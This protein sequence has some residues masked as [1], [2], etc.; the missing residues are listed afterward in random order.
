MDEQYRKDMAKLAERIRIDR[1]I[2]TLLL[3][4]DPA[5]KIEEL[6]DERGVDMVMMA[7]HGRG[8]FRRF[9]MGSVTAK[10]LNDV[11][12]PVFTGVH[13]PEVAKFT[14]DPYVRV[15]CAVD[16]RGQSEKV[17]AWATEF[18]ASWKA[19]LIL[20]HAAPLVGSD[21]VYGSFFPAD[22][23]EILLRSA[24]E[25]VEQLCQKV[26]CR[27]EVHVATADAVPYVRDVAQKTYADVLIIGRSVNGVLQGRLRTHA[28]ALIRESPCPVISV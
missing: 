10:V 2:E 27:P 9:I 4:G 7:T 25:K 16:L 18:A 28:Y 23:G 19:D 6:I 26:G 17:L 20:I 21:E 12:C 5:R 22:A 15:A 24:R 3:H 14:G 11:S 8:P 1:A 13:I